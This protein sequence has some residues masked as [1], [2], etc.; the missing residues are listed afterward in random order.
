MRFVSKKTLAFISL[1]LVA[2]VPLSAGFVGT[3]GRGGGGGAS[4]AYTNQVDGNAQAEGYFSHA[5]REAAKALGYSGTSLS[6]ADLYNAAKGRSASSY[7]TQHNLTD[8]NS[9]TIGANHYETDCDD[10]ILLNSSVTGDGCADLTKTQFLAVRTNTDAATNA[11]FD[12]HTQYKAANLLGYTKVCAD[13]DLYLEAIGRSASACFS[14]SLTPPDSGDCTTY[15]SDN[16]LTDSDS[17]ALAGCSAMTKTQYNAFKTWNDVQLATTAVTTATTCSGIT[18]QNIR[19]FMNDQSV[20]NSDFDFDNLTTKQTDFLTQCIL[21]KGDSRTVAQAKTC[22]S[23]K[24]DTDLALY[25]IKQIR[26]AGGAGCG[27]SGTYP[28]TA[29]TTSVMRRAGVWASA[30]DV[31]CSSAFG[32]NFCETSGSTVACTNILQDNITSA[33]TSNVASSSAISSW[34]TAKVKANLLAQWNA[35]T[36]PHFIV[37]ACQSATHEKPDF[38]K[39]PAMKPTYSSYEWKGMMADPS[40]NIHVYTGITGSPH[41]AKSL[42]LMGSDGDNF[43][44]DIAGNVK[45]RKMRDVQSTLWWTNS[46]PAFGTSSAGTS[47]KYALS[48]VKNA[49]DATANPLTSHFIPTQVYAPTYLC[50]ACQGDSPPSW[51]DAALSLGNSSQWQWNNTQTQSSGWAGNFVCSGKSSAGQIGGAD[52]SQPSGTPSHVKCTNAGCGTGQPDTYDTGIRC[53]A[54]HATYNGSTYSN[55]TFTIG[56]A[57][58]TKK[59]IS[60]SGEVAE[61]GTMKIAW[62]DGTWT[63]VATTASGAVHSWSATSPSPQSRSSAKIRLDT[64]DAIGRTSNIAAAYPDYFNNGS[65]SN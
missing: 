25:E 3:G 47:K 35:W 28:T 31:S 45:K 24:T 23:G 59:S 44:F 12:D 43:R 33:S 13:S 4:G 49:T 9:S 17:V 30:D 15:I 64:S 1:A 65:C 18:K 46:C 21:D 34:A 19:L 54:P 38:M 41:T 56:A 10:Y 40:T 57:S 55:Y 32:G 22:G 37:E 2:A 11:G 63:S 16:S 60:I 53:M 36:A 50:N 6:D 52:W 51:C 7:P 29:L 58:G 14:T 27:A 8:S 20:S 48:I 62:C 39:S 5:E 26:A 42:A 61:S